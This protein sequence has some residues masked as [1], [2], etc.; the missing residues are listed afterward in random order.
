MI[1][2]R[3]ICTGPERFEFDGFFVIPPVDIW[4]SGELF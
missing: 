3:L 2:D 4:R 1:D